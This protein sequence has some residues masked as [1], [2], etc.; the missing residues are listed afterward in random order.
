VRERVTERVRAGVRMR[1]RTA[2]AAHAQAGT[3]CGVCR[4]P[5]RMV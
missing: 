1:V 5:L 3:R 2:R 4:Y